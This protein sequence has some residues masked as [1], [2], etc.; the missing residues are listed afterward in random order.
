MN[1]W[2]EIEEMRV[3]ESKGQMLGTFI[4]LEMQVKSAKE[5]LSRASRVMF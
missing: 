1:K 4:F 2:I 5:V 3:F